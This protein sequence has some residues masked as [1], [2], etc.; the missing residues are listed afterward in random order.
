MANNIE[1]TANEVT[2]RTKP[3]RANPGTHSTIGW[4][5]AKKGAMLTTEENGFLRSTNG[6]SMQLRPS[7]FHSEIPHSEKKYAH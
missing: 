7:R 4:F 2:S 1:L 3:F 5:S 6:E